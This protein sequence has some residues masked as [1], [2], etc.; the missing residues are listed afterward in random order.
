MQIKNSYFWFDSI[1]TP[2][3]CQK[4]IDLGLSKI[5]E[6]K[7]NGISTV[8]STAGDLDKESKPNAM[9]A[10]GIPISE[11]PDTK[12]VYI[13]DSQV[14]WLSD[15]WL[16]DLIYPIAKEANELAGWNYDFDWAESFQFTQYNEGGFYSWHT[17]GG[18][19]RDAIYKRYLHGITEIPLRPDG[20]FPFGYLKQNQ[21]IGKIRKVSMTINLNKPG[22][23]EGGNLMFDFGVHT[24]KENRFHECTEIR[25]QGSAIVFPSYMHHCVTPVTK[26]TRYS[27]VMWA[28]G[29]P[30]K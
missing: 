5:E 7:Q 13:R 4:I 9:P 29:R 6:A 20:K 15:Q 28:V 8:G 27:L 10:N 25:N 30:F 19:D 24:N 18:S 23:Y 11:L 22:E 17:D 12:N 14:A 1:L 2:E 21:F 26:G 3:I 16:Y